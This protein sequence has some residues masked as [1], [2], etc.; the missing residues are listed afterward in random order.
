MSTTDDVV[1]R[2][3]A[4]RLHAD[5]RHYTTHRNVIRHLKENSDI[6]HDSYARAVVHEQDGKTCPTCQRQLKATYTNDGTMWWTHS[7]GPFPPSPRYR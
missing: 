2:L 5:H 3:L 7:D 6:V 1:T 4:E